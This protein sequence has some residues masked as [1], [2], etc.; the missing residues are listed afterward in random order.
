MIGAEDDVE[1][2]LSTEAL[3]GED[4][5]DAVVE[6]RPFKSYDDVPGFPN[7]HELELRDYTVREPPATE[8]FGASPSETEY[9]DDTVALAREIMTDFLDAGD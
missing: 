7:C 6:I 3:P 1:T 8:T 4:G 2:D 5:D 9:L